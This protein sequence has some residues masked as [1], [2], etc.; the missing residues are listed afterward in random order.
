[1]NSCRRYAI[2]AGAFSGSYDRP[3]SIV[4]LAS[5]RSSLGLEACN[6]EARCRLRLQPP[7]SGQAVNCNGAGMVGIESGAQSPGFKRRF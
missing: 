7:P 5:N 6:D 2:I 1:M 4:G 3:A